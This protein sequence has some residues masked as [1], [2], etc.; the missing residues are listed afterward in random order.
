M[1]ESGNFGIFGGRASVIIVGAV[2]ALQEKK[3]LKTILILF[4]FF[5]DN[6]DTLIY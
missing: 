3:D 2:V 6:F 4:H 5:L 1:L